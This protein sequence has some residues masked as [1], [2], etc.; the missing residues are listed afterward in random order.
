MITINAK[1]EE[2]DEL[3]NNFQQQIELIEKIAQATEPKLNA[4]LPEPEDE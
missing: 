3:P 4:H 1:F 2:Y